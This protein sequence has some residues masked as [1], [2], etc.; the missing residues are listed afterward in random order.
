MADHT[1]TSQ[2]VTSYRLEPITADLTLN[3]GEKLADMPA[4]QNYALRTVPA[5]Y[6]VKLHVDI[7]GEVE[8]L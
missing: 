1:I 5:G 2:I 7:T 4:V 6:Q 3:A 8:K